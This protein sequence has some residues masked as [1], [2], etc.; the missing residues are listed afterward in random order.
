MGSQQVE[1]VMGNR[2]I[3]VKILV[4]LHSLQLDLHFLGFLILISSVLV[5]I[6]EEE[7]G[8]DQLVREIEYH[9]SSVEIGFGVIMVP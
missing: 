7:Y 1:G 4:E 2:R 9:H 8:V 6:T 5:L 3:Y